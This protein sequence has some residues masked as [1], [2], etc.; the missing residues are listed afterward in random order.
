MRLPLTSLEPLRSLSGCAHSLGPD[1]SEI[2]ADT[3]AMTEGSWTC[4]EGHE[5]P[6]SPT[7]PLV[8][9]GHLPCPVCGSKT[10]RASQPVEA[11]VATNSSLNMTVRPTGGGKP[12]VEQFEGAQWSARLGRFVRKSR[13]IDR[14]QDRYRETVDDPV[15]GERLHHEDHPLSEHRDHGSEKGRGRKPNT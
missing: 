11:S 13:T 6:D 9:G 7:D 15:T 1:T 10:R 8:D 3:G 14:L 5:V 12:F 4:A 2:G